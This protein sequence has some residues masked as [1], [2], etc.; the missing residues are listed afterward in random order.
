M[1]SYTLS[2]NQTILA[3]EFFRLSARKIKNPTKVLEYINR[4]T[5]R[6]Q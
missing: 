3:V 5:Q 1:K 6:A 2:L 4:K